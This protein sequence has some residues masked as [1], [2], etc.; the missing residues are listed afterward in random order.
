MVDS[1]R[2][3]LD[4]AVAEPPALVLQVDAVIAARPPG[5]DPLD[6]RDHADWCDPVLELDESWV[7]QE[8]AK[9]VGRRFVA[10]QG[11]NVEMAHAAEDQTGVE[12]SLQPNDSIPGSFE[13]AVRLDRG[14]LVLRR[15]LKIGPRDNW[16]VIAA[17]RISRRLPEPKLEVRIDGQVVRELT[18]SSGSGDLKDVPPL[19]ASLAEVPREERS[20]SR[21][22]DS[23][24]CGERRSAGSILGHSRQLRKSRHCT[25]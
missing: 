10:W 2:I 24:A 22:R 20:C 18:V 11:W 13:P 8:F 25:R 21:H 14:S 15:E 12:F 19:V 3:S 1:G 5:A 16:L 4:R 17:T 7:K 9:R 23:A 6:I